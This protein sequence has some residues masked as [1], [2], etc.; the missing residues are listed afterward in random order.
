MP[1]SYNAA[2]TADGGDNLDREGYTFVC[3]Q[4]DS[5]FNRLAH[6]RRHEMTRKPPN[7][8]LSPYLPTPRRQLIAVVFATPTDG[9]EKPYNCLY[10][11]VASTRKDVIVRHTR[12][13]HPA[14]A[15]R[16]S[17][18]SSSRSAPG[19]RAKRS[20]TNPE[21]TSHD[22]PSP[23]TGHRPSW[24]SS[25]AA[26]M[27]NDQEPG[28]GRNT[29]ADNY[30]EE[31]PG[32]STTSHPGQ[33]DLSAILPAHADLIDQSL[34]GHSPLDF[35]GPFMGQDFDYASISEDIDM[36]LLMSNPDDFLAGITTNAGKLPAAASDSSGTRLPNPRANLSPGKCQDRGP[37]RDIRASVDDANNEWAEALSNLAR[38]PAEIAASFHFP[39]KHAA[40][41]FVSAFFGHI[42]P[43]IPIVHE[44]SFDIATVPCKSHASKA[45]W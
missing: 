10:C 19:H 34:L 36:D 4:C 1:A 28:S 43:H 15:S 41:R 30:S 13:F 37:G 44:P 24:A 25:T 40:R 32:S 27:E 2:D 42:A 5:R 45:D 9:G 39:S 14:A 35:T 11:P 8:G 16:R 17:K 7:F 29:T 31:T 18:A 23:A 38:Y 33:V 6:L 20:R 22:E 3:P 26:T 21:A 12:N